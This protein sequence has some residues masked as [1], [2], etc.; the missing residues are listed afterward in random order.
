MLREADR[1]RFKNANHP[2]ICSW[3]LIMLMKNLTGFSRLQT[4][5]LS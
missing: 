3:K 4:L 5:P 1:A 2:C